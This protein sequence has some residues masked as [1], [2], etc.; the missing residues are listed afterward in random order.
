MVG[1]DLI[2]KIILKEKG[3]FMGVDEPFRKRDKPVQR[4]KGESIPGL[5]EKQKGG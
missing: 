4:S 2:E 3:F 5:F 1:V